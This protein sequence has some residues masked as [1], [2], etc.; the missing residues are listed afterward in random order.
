ML[1]D[2]QKNT[3]QYKERVLWAYQKGLADTGAWPTEHVSAKHSIDTLF[4]KLRRFEYTDP[5]PGGT[6]SCFHCPGNFINN[7]NN[8]IATTKDYFDGL[9]LGKHTIPSL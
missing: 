1:D 5:H 9:C 8:A 4:S 2:D 3:C 6:T 7:V